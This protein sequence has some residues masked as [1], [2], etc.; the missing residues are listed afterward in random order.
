MAVE[1]GKREAILEIDLRIMYGHSIPEVVIK[2][3][4]SVARRLLEICGLVAKEINIDVVGIDFPE[5]TL[6]LVE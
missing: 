6:G 4:E 5:R 1:A 3:R 2:V